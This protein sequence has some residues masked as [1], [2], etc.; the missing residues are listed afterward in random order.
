M[1]HQPSGGSSG[2]ASDLEIQVK[3]IL[4]TRKKLN[5]IY[6]KHLTKSHTMDELMKHMD[7]DNFMDAEEALEFGLID[8]ILTRREVDDKTKAD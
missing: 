7:R 5:E 8:K 3:E 2:Q 6:Q 4:R 1:I